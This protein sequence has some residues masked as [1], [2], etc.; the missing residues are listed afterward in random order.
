MRFS[1]ASLSPSPLQRWA[2]A[3]EPSE[4]PQIYLLEDVTGAGKTEAAVLLA[5]RLMA[6]GQ[7]D[8][9]FLGLPTMATANAMYG[10]IAQVYARLFE[11]N[12]SLVLGAWSARP[13]GGF[14]GIGHSRWRCRDG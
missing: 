8:G 4:G 3:T 14:R 5:H 12:A 7:A 6:A 2:A 11:G 13:G 9:F 1:R 10:R